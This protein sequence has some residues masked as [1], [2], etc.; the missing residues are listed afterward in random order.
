MEL[1]FS[2]LKVREA[3]TQRDG[4]TCSKSHSG[5]VV[6]WDMYLYLSAFATELAALSERRNLLRIFLG[7]MECP[8][9]KEP[10]GKWPL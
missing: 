8:R 9:G 5:T 4:P 6:G 2:V 1:F 7:N 10:G 3:K